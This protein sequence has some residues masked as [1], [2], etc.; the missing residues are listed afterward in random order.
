MTNYVLSDREL[1]EVSAYIED[2]LIW[3]SEKLLKA[4]P[5]LVSE[6]RRRRGTN[7]RELLDLSEMLDDGAKWHSD[8][9]L[10]ALPHV[11]TELRRRRGIVGPTTQKDT[12]IDY[13]R[14]AKALKK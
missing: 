4:M 14:V 11:V 5:Y 13:K 2:G 1:D 6:L 3:H 10:P 8:K 12:R 9:L 7:S